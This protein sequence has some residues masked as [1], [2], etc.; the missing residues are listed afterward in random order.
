[1]RVG[2]LGFRRGFTLIELL[3][4]VTIISILI[5]LLLPAVQAARAS[6]RRMQCSNNL[7]QIG[8]ALSDYVDIQGINGKYPDAAQMPSVPLLGVKKPSLR[9]V[10]GPFIEENV[11]VFHCP[12]DCSYQ[13]GTLPGSYF[14]NEGLSYEYRWSRAA[15]PYPKTR[16]DLRLWPFPTGTEQPSSEIY[17]VYDF[18]PVHAPPGSIGSHMFLYAD[19]HV[20]Y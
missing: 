20:D 12:S 16:V 3:V 13:N 11:N 5:A 1:M 7:H 14:S 15:S 4:V 9:D 2:A 19:G 6:A 18:E 17:L 8:I 10:L